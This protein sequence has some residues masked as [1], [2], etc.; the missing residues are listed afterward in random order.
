MSGWNDM[1]NRKYER[2]R[3][4]ADTVTKVFG[5]GNN[6]NRKIYLYSTQTLNFKEL[7]WKEM[8]RKNGTETG[9]NSFFS[10]NYP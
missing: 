10:P 9:E 1:L 3:T 2:E 5:E 7:A 8:R 4:F 6:K